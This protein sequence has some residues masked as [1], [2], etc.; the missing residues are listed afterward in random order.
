MPRSKSQRTKSHKGRPSQPETP[1]F[2]G[3]GAADLA[4]IALAVNG[5]MLITEI[6][7]AIGSAESNA[8]VCVR[9]LQQLGL[10]VKSKRKRNETFIALNLGFAAHKELHALLLELDRTGPVSR[11]RRPQ[12]PRKIPIHMI[13]ARASSKELRKSVK[14]RILTFVALTDNVDLKLIED[15]L[16]LDRSSIAKAVN[17]WEEEGVLTS[18]R[19]GRRRLIDVNRAFPASAELQAFL[20]KVR[21]ET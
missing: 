19:V 16:G 3:K 14:L 12:I 20:K 18:C 2:F 15:A 7:T 8:F 17:R 9:H 10:I 5:P 11:M 1:R 6:A 13:S 21:S 4:L